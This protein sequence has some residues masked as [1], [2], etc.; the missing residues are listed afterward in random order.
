M[1]GNNRMNIAKLVGN[2]EFYT[3]YGD[4]Q[5]EVNAYLEYDP[6]TF[7]DKTVLL[8]C[9]DPDWSKFTR[10]FAENFTNFGLKKLIS[11]SYAHASKNVL[12]DWNPTEFETNNLNYDPVKSR[13]HGKVFTIDRDTHDDKR[14]DINNLEWHYLNGTGDFNS[15]EVKALRDE[16]DIIITNPPFS[17]FRKFIKWIFDGGKKFLIIGN[18][19]AITYK[20]VFPLVKE[21]KLWVGVTP[22]SKD[23]HFFIPKYY[24][25]NVL[26]A[27]RQTA[28][29]IEEG[30]ILGRSPAVWLTNLEH[31][32]RHEEL[33]LLTMADNIKYSKHKEIRGL[34][35]KKY[36]NYD[37]IDVPY[38][39]A[40]PS[41][42]EDVMG[43]PI[44]FLDKYCPNQFELIGITEK[45]TKFTKDNPLSI[46]QIPNCLKY[47]RP[48]INGKRKYARI[49]IRKIKQQ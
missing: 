8:P 47:D 49:F 17:Q 44:T 25:D 32:R 26:E 12:F 13:T 27:N 42:Y 23:L 37:A 20:E 40:I 6:N 1:A 15:P 39:D 30:N 19:N 10:F 46:L 5:A 34:G 22:M 2:D 18:K 31:G 41:D 28:I 35:Y 33:H 14:I 48:Y 3:Q 29:A 36:D 38:S 21:N 7:R 24:I 16:S 43:V 45:N 4:I 9:D 11:T